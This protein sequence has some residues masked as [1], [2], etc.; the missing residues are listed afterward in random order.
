VHAAEMQVFAFIDG[1]EIEL[2]LNAGMLQDLDSSCEYWNRNPPFI[3]GL[4]SRSLLND[5]DLSTYVTTDGTTDTES[6]RIDL[7][8]EFPISRVVIY[9][10]Q[11]CCQDRLNECNL[12]LR[13]QTDRLVYTQAFPIPAQQVYNFVW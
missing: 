1:R 9:N 8:R 12:Q 5:G 6:I 10:R 7:L 4:K 13:D 2:P 11:D 3:R